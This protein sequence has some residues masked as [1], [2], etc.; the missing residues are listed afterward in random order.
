MTGKLS[1]RLTS[2]IDMSTDSGLPLPT[3]IITRIF[4]YC[5]PA[6]T[7]ITPSPKNAPL[8]LAQI[9]HPWRDICLDTPSLWASIGCDDR[10]DP[11]RIELLE[12]WLS[13]GR[14]R[15]LSVY[16]HS[17]NVARATAVMRAVARH[18]SR[19]EDAQLIFPGSVHQQL[20]TLTFPRLK[21]LVILNYILPSTPGVG[22]VT[23]QDAPL[24]QQAIIINTCI[25]L[26]SPLGQLTSLRLFA[27][28]ATVTEYIAV[29]RCCPN[30]LDLNC[31]G[32]WLGVSA[33][34]PLELEL[35]LLRSLKIP[36][37]QLCCGIWS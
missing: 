13:R 30:L 1:L 3:E 32:E 26:D 5:L 9:C 27:P 29:L 10:Y 12:V 35:S 34:P 22:S 8:L 7:Y 4:D 15:P 11:M 24:L 18:S 23:I 16:L 37:A 14:S 21:H 17:R 6:E 20:S 19:L 36:D 2:T 31:G 28:R 25:T 33:P